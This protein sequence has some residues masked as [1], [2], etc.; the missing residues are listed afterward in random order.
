MEKQRRKRY[1]LGFREVVHA[2][3]VEWGAR[4]SAEPGAADLAQRV[5]FVAAPK[6]RSLRENSQPGAGQNGPSQSAR[7]KGCG[8]GSG[9]RTQDVGSGFFSGCLAKTRRQ[10][11]GDG[12]SW[13]NILCEEI[14]ERKDSQG[15]LSVERMCWLG[16]VQPGQCLPSMGRGRRRSGNWIKNLRA[17]DS[18]RRIG[19][20]VLRLSP[21]RPLCSRSRPSGECETGSALDA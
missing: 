18:T 12:K 20:S 1:G 13:R 21:D 9:C 5:I 16:Q 19:A 11:P 15:G 8:V 2:A 4:Q 17:S 3:D 7:S 6:R 10:W 14:R